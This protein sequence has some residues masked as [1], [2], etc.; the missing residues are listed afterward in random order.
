MFKKIF[1]IIMCLI[2][3][4]YL[5]SLATLLQL[6]SASSAQSGQLARDA[7]RIIVQVR[8]QTQTYLYALLQSY[9]S[10]YRL[11]H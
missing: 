10:H 9:S 1:I 7:H 3:C 2:W 6:R 8:L 5:F 4:L 11:V